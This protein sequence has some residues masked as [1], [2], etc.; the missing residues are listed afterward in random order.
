MKLKA[1]F[2]SVLAGIVAAIFSYL[3]LISPATHAAIDIRRRMPDAWFSSSIVWY[4]TAVV[5]GISLVIAGIVY[6]I[7]YRQ[8]AGP[9]P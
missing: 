9:R 1:I 4:A 8:A 6:R 2:E 5:L 7:V 3:A